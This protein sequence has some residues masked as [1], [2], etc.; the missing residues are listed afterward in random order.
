MFDWDRLFAQ[1]CADINDGRRSEGPVKKRPRFVIENNII[2]EDNITCPSIG[3]CINDSTEIRASRTESDHADT[4]DE[5][6][7]A[8]KEIQKEWPRSIFYKMS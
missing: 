7:L 4:T 1:G 6:N 5:I 3:R 8:F 2:H